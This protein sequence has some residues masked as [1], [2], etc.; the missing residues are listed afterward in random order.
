MD[1]FLWDASSR[2]P[3]GKSIRKLKSGNLNIKMK[4]ASLIASDSKHV[5]DFTTT[6]GHFDNYLS[7]EPFCKKRI[8]ISKFKANAQLANSSFSQSAQKPKFIKRESIG[9]IANSSSK[10]LLEMTNS[11]GMLKFVSTTAHKDTSFRRPIQTN[12]YLT[13]TVNQDKY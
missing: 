3:S 4:R 7:N 1:K 11:K 13:S 9:N 10:D 8:D 12:N 2:S 6:M 5:T